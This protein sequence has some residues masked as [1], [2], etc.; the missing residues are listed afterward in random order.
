M[1]VSSENFWLT[2]SKKQI[3]K[4]IWKKERDTWTDRERKREKERKRK[5]EKRERRERQANSRK[6]V[7]AV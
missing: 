7:K 5:R 2:I 4:K 1:L 6:N 3:L